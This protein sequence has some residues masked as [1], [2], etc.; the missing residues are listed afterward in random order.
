MKLGTEK[1]SSIEE[2]LKKFKCPSCKAFYKDPR[3]LSC[4]HCLCSE[5][6]M[7]NKKSAGQET[8]IEIQCIVPD[9]GET[10]IIG[11]TK[12]EDAPKA[13]ILIEECRQM[14]STISLADNI[15]EELKGIIPQVPKRKC[16]E[17]ENCEDIIQMCQA[18]ECKGLY[19][20]LTHSKQH[21]QKSKNHRLFDVGEEDEKNS[22]DSVVFCDEQ[23]H[24]ENNKA[25]F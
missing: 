18:P 8:Q 22:L 5:C 11:S 23:G 16:C 17:G 9:C 24:D 25:Q 2:Q 15:K 13:L 14:I 1:D 10:T 6:L 21:R 3:Q 12:L 20:C 19:I 7:K 4:L